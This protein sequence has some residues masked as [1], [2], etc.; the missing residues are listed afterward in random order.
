MSNLK[1]VRVPDLGNV[2][3]AAII[4]IPIKVGESIQAEQA[5]ITLESDKASMDIPAPFAGK[6]KEIKVKVGDKV[7]KGDFIVLLETEADTAVAEEKPAAKKETTETAA[8][9]VQ[10][11]TAKPAETITTVVNTEDTAVSSEDDDQGDVHAGPG[12]R[13]LAREFGLNLNLITGTGQK[14]RVVKEDLQNF[15]KSRLNQTGQSS[16]TGAGLPSAPQIDF[17]QFGET[18]NKPLSRIKKLSAQYLHRNWLLVPHVTQFNEADITELEAFRK[19]Q[20]AFAAKQ[21]VKLTPLVFIM[22]A[23]VTALKEFPAFNASLSADGEQLILKKYFHIGI[24]VDTPE[25]LVVPVI[26][27]V[28]KKSLLE[29]AKELAEV[30]NKARLKQLSSADMQGSSFTISSLGGIG[31]TAFTPIVNLPDVAIL[32]VSKAQFKPQYQDG[33]F[34]P[35]LMLP[36]CLSYDHR[37]IDGAEGAR[38]SVFLADCLSD[39]RRWL[40]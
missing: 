14:G 39:I 19:A 27:D 36:L 25:G 3:G 24:A 7:S 30:S 22:K 10:Q 34:I 6:V 21:N 11:E 16:G 5:L 13:R 29:L 40:L 15:V 26:R 33:E 12:V 35:R 8:A 28:D 31:G 2:S 9:N 32:G 37:V 17:S 20:A 1:E 23:V 38:F 18:E 4:E